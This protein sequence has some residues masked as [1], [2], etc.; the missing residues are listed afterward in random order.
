MTWYA[1]SMG[2]PKEKPD[3]AV[4]GEIDAFFTELLDDDGNFIEKSTARNKT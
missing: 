4:R 3:K 2:M 1:N